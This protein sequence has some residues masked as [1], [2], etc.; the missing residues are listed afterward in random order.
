MT[1]IVVLRAFAS[2][3]SALTGVEAISNGVS[4]F[5]PPKSKNAARTLGVMGLI[6]IS[7]FLGVSYLAV[8]TGARPSES[9]SCSP[10]SREQFSRLIGLFDPLLRRPGTTLAILVLAANTS[11][12]GFPRLAAVL[13]SDRFF[14]RQFVN[15]GDRLVY[16]NGIIV[17]AA[18]AALLIWAFHADVISL[19]H[20]YVIGV[21]TAFTLSQ[22]GMVRHGRSS[23]P[24]RRWRA[25]VNGFGAAATGLVTIVVIQ[26]KFTQGAWMVIVAVPVLIVL[27]LLV[28][29]HYRGVARR[30]RARS[31]AVKSVVSATNRVVVYVESLDE[32]TERAAWYAR[33]ITGGDYTA[34]YVPGNGGRI[35]AE[36]GGTSAASRRDA[37]RERQAGR[38]APRLCLGAPPQ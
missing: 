2:G 3:A 37:A 35:R 16:S 10:R 13:A 28:N 6:A 20:L 14:P 7:L 38:A 9:V 36:A 22:A 19:I 18:V 27:F 32:A 12:Q 24:G 1:L 31:G 15:L 30:L 5:K 26:T 23:D 33:E 21:F 17:L 25:V 29:R 11:Y 8:K 4:A 34:V